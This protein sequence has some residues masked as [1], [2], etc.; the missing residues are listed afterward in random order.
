MELSDQNSYLRLRILAP[1]SL[2]GFGIFKDLSVQIMLDQKR[3]R[4]LLNSYYGLSKISYLPDILKM[5]GVMKE[6]EIEK[7]GKIVDLKERSQ[8][9]YKALGIIWGR[10][11][12]K[13]NMIERSKAKHRNAKNR[14]R[15]NMKIDYSDAKNTNINQ[16]HLRP[17]KKR[18]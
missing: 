14:H 6:Q 13:T 10:L 4:A 16:G 12:A 9:V 8:A 1:K 18:L 2:M 17:S 3:H 5:M 7:P 11:D 15:V